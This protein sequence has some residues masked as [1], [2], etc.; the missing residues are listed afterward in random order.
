VPSGNYTIKIV[1]IPR[2][3]VPSAAPMTISVGSGMMISGAFAPNP[4]VP[5]IPAEPTM[6]ASVPVAVGDAD[7]TGVNIALNTGLRVSGRVEFEGAA[8]KPA[9]E[10]LS[11]IPVMLEPVDGQMDRNVTP[12]GRIDAKGQFTSYGLPAGRYYVRSSA[13]TGWTLK[14]AFLGERDLSDVALDLEST[15]VADV[16]LTFT[17]RPA[18]LSGTVQMTERAARD[19]VAVIVF[20][21]DS[22]AWMETGVN[23]RRMRKVATSDTGAYNVTPLPAGAYYVAA[24]SETVAGDWQDPAFLEQLAAS[25]AHVQIDN[26]E[27]ATMSLRLLEIR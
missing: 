24:L 21:A 5:P 11:R 13:P 15:D 6:W 27:K 3:A 9:P 26:G 8:D 16:V 12:P 4:E 19:G 25:A 17:D 22:K 2:S 14:G 7:V 18:S 23:P 1:Q 20:P 10:Q